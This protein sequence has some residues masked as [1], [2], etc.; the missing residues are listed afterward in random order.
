M[1]MADQREAGC[2]RRS[3]VTYSENLGNIS[4]MKVTTDYRSTHKTLDHAS[5]YHDFQLGLQHLRQLCL[6]KQ[7]PHGTHAS[8]VP[9]AHQPFTRPTSLQARF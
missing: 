5:K 7:L 6:T 1:N 3:D 9:S 8:F 2:F 4:T